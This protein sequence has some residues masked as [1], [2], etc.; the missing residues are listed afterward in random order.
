MSEE[1]RKG[2]QE[3]RD[4]FN[5]VQQDVVNSAK[6]ARQNRDALE[7]VK[8]AI[9]DHDKKTALTGQKVDTVV[10]VVGRIEQKVDTLQTTVTETRV[11]ADDTR[12]GLDKTR[13]QVSLLH[14]LVTRHD[15]K[16]E[17]S[18]IPARLMVCVAG[19]GFLIYTGYHFNSAAMEATVAA[20]KG[21]F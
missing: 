14:D 21:L 12:L 9:A 15:E 19:F 4:S 1:R 5:E 7:A 18:K 8:Q 17:N 2:F 16:L 6:E 11:H 10:G 13:E 3:L 20:L